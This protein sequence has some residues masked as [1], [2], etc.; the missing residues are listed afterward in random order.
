MLPGESKKEDTYCLDSFHLPDFL[1]PFKVLNAGKVT[2]L[3]ENL[4]PLSIFSRQVVACITFVA[5]L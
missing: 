1:E 5:V 4:S 3:K 2:I